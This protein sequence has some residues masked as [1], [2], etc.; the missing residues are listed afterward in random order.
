MPING[1]TIFNHLH[2]DDEKKIKK[3]MSSILTEEFENITIEYRTKNADNEYRWLSDKWNII[4][5]EKG[6][7]VGYEGIMRDITDKKILELE[8]KKRFKYSELINK[9]LILATKN[10][11]YQIFSNLM[12]KEIGEITNVSRTYIFEKI[13]NQ[14]MNNISE[15]CNKGIEPQIENLKK[16]DMNYFPDWIK[17]LKLNNIIKA[18]DIEKDLPEEVHELL[19]IQ[20]IKSVLVV[21]LFVKEELYGFLGFDECINYKEWKEL[22]I[23]L[24]RTVA[25]I[26]SLLLEKKYVKN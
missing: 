3:I 16:V 24:I 18:K 8:L 5:N 4:K 14:F 11:S 13:D 15:W 1:E 17:E 12:L 19:K 6:I 21:P 25:N 26:I 2:P 10:D 9:I 20:N 7:I 23:E 22:D